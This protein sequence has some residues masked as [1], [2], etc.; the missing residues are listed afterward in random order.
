MCTRVSPL[1]NTYIIMYHL[2]NDRVFEF[3]FAQINLRADLQFE[4]I[5]LHSSAQTPAPLKR[6]HAH[7][8]PCMTKPDGQ[9][10]Q[11]PAKH[12]CVELFKSFPYKWNC[13]F[14]LNE[15]IERS[16]P[17]HIYKLKQVATPSNLHL[18]R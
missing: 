8:S 9:L 12:L 13:R 7:K 18:Q 14:H 4:I 11:L 3:T 1:M 17:L 5:I 2:V 6:T 10:R 16:S 15:Y